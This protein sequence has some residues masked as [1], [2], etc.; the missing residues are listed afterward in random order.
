MANCAGG[1]TYYHD[2]ENLLWDILFHLFN[3]LH[4]YIGGRACHRM[5][6]EAR[7]Q[8]AEVGSL[9]LLVGSFGGIILSMVNMVSKELTGL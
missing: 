7:G 6:A 5:H 1:A 4:T 2:T 9:I 8:P 3:F